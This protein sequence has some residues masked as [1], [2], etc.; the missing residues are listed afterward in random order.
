MCAIA[1]IRQTAQTT[2]HGL[3]WGGGIAYPLFVVCE[4]ATSKNDTRRNA[5]S[6][7]VALAGIL[8]EGP[9]FQNSRK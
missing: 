4:L 7:A 2:P 3:S 5:F 1:P 6:M 8:R 9:I